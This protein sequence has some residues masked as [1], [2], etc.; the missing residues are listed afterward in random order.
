MGEKNVITHV[1]RSKDHVIGV[2]VK[3]CAA[4]KS[5]AGMIPV[6]DVMGHLVATW[7]M[8]VFFGQV[9]YCLKLTRFGIG[10]N[11]LGFFGITNHLTFIDLVF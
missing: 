2:E 9:R 1:E 3:A 11:I 5:L 4:L 10:D 8:S 6:M 7:G